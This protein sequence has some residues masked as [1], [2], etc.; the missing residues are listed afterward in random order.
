MVMGG[1]QSASYVLIT[2]CENKECLVLLMQVGTL[3]MT[4]SGI[5]GHSEQNVSLG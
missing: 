2:C 5:S 4:K 1:E 3:Q